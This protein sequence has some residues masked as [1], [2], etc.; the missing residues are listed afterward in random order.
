MDINMTIIYGY[1]TIIHYY[2]KMKFYGSKFLFALMPS[3]Y[4]MQFWRGD[5]QLKTMIFEN[6]DDGV[7]CYFDAKYGQI[8]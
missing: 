1:F 4:L 3:M 2:I 8:K 6:D 5:C 7:V